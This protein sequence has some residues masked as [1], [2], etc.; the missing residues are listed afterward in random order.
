M[1]QLKKYSAK[2]LKTKN[3]SASNKD[4][5]EV[6]SSKAARH[7]ATNLGEVKTGKSLIMSHWETKRMMPFLKTGSSLP[8]DRSARMH[9][10]LPAG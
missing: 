10:S 4:I 2:E 3:V 8:L 5:F 1:R 9:S 6:K 7:R